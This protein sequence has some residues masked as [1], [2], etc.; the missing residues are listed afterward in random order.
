A[1]LR[2]LA[3]DDTAEMPGRHRP[4]RRLARRYDDRLDQFQLVPQR[5]IG[6]KIRP[7]QSFDRVADHRFDGLAG[8]RIGRRRSYRI[9][10]HEFL[11]SRRITG[12][13]L[14]PTTFPVTLLLLF[15]KKP[16]QTTTPC[17]GYASRPGPVLDRP[18]AI[19]VMLPA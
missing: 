12:K 7:R 18:I 19:R 2:P 15:N 11:P 16:V 17:V 9:G 5:A 14:R 8:R 4:G 13:L 1:L 10:L 6:R 3:A